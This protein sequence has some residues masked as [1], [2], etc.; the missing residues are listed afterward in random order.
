M[1]HRSDNT[2]I[3]PSIGN[4]TLP[5]ARLTLHQEIVSVQEESNVP[6]VLKAIDLNRASKAVDIEMTNAEVFDLFTSPEHPTH[7]AVTHEDLVVGM[8]HRDYFMELMAQPFTRELYGKKSCRKFMDDHPVCID[9]QTP[10]S[11]LADRLLRSWNR[12]RLSA[13][14]VITVDGRFYG[15]GLTGDVLAAMLIQ[16]R[17]LSEELSRANQQLKELSTRDG[18]TGLYNRR[19]FNQVM[20]YELR[21]AQREHYGVGLILYDLD[22]FKKLNDALGHQAGDAAL[23]AVSKCMAS[24]LRRSSDL[25][26]RL[27]GEEFAVLVAPAQPDN[28]YKLADHLRSCVMEL[29]ISHPDHPLGVV[30][31]SAG[32]A[33]SDPDGESFS[34]LYERADQA[35]YSAKKSGRNCVVSASVGIAES[36]IES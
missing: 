4:S 20:E 11:Q 29:A 34:C 2:N 13:G 12:T 14:F 26:F 23:I 17:L 19:H 24:H 10:I 5:N 36:Q 31:V 22:F 15:T 25:V 33:V 6:V 18:L 9:A 7:I 32:I 16:E 35:L 8:I 21:R 3:K 27:G 28:M 30:S 1:K